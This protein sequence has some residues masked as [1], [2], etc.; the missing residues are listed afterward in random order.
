MKKIILDLRDIPTTA[1]EDWADSSERSQIENAILDHA[2]LIVVV[3]ITK[4]RA[5]RRLA[6][7]LDKMEGQPNE[8]AAAEGVPCV[9][10]GTGTL[11]PRSRLVSWPI[12]M[13][14][15]TGPLAFDCI[16][17]EVKAEKGVNNAK[18]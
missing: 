3:R 6:E 15:S 9:W 14:L 4:Y 1:G 12:W 16:L 18:R 10:S 13:V 11:A 17:G 8:R 7:R 5:S 2:G